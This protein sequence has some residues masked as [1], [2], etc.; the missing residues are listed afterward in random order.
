MIT[1]RFNKA[2]QILEVNYAGSIDKVDIL[3]FGIWVANNKELP[4]ELK[5]LTNACDAEY[6]I[7]KVDFNELMVAL[8]NNCKFYKCIKAAYTQRK[9]IETA[10]STLTS[11][12]STIPNYFHAVFYSKEAAIAWLL[13]N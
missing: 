8:E 13:S 3:E 5:I 12:R 9:P 11:Y 6:K 2:M 4:R 7:S 10:L 1:Y